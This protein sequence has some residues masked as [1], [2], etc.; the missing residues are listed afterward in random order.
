VPT[1]RAPSSIEVEV[2]RIRELS[3][4]GHYSE[5]LAAAEALVLHVPQNRDVLY[6]I[7]ANQRCLNRTIR[8]LHTL[9]QLEQH[10][11]RF[12]LLFQERGYCCMALGD[13][14]RAI[15]AFAQAVKLNAALVS[16]WTML[17]RLYSV[18]GQ[19]QNAANA[20]EHLSVLKQLPSE[21]VRAAIHFSDGDLSAAAHIL[22]SYLEHGHT[23]VEALR[24]LARIERERNALHEAT[25][26]LESTLELVPNSRS[27]RVDYVRIL[28]DEQKYLQ[29]YNAIVGLWNAE[30]TDS[31][32]L[33]LSAAACVGLGRHERAIE[34]Y[35]QSLAASPHSAELHVVLGHSLQSI[36]R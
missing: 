31:E 1:P 19:P 20:S 17:E 4:T 12:S 29:A 24:L 6:L 32:L 2:G 36:G 23:H 13:V 22:R 15:E 18:T 27:A 10:H 16:S 7:A 3:K 5:A 26:L 34:L 21:V 30:E 8:A 11:P 33:S 25:K 14:R 28:L 35:R 9:E